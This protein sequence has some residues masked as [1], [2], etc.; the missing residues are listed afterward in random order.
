MIQEELNTFSVVWDATSHLS[1][2]RVQREVM[3][4]EGPVPEGSSIVPALASGR[5]LAELAFD[6]FTFDN[7]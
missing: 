1:S 2:R 7:A 3:R 4:E 5:G 6:P